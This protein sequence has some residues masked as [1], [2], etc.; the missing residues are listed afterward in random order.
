MAYSSTAESRVENSAQVL[1]GKLK[2]VH[3]QSEPTIDNCRIW[4][5]VSDEERSFVTLAPGWA[6]HIRP[7]DSRTLEEPCWKE[8]SC[9]G[10]DKIKS[11]IIFKK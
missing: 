10:G 5:S 4:P 7:L 2:F 11:C 6:N 3:D 1:S 8:E 9:P